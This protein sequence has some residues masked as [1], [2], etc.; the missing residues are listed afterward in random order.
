MAYEL[1]IYPPNGARQTVTSQAVVAAF[2]A[3]GLPCTEQP[4]QY[5]Y[6]L[7]L[8]GVESALDLTIKDGAVTGAGFRFVSRDDESVIQRVADV[9]KS[10]GFMVSDD[11]G[12]L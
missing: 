9:F 5:G 8:D 1:I 12:E 3:A 10:F 2:I 4:D 6:W 11:E 7:V